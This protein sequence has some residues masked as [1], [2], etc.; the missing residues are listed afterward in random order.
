MHLVFHPFG[1]LVSRFVV[2]TI[3]F[4][5]T[6][7]K[8]HAIFIAVVII[9][10]RQMD[11]HV[12]LSILGAPGH[13]CRRGGQLSTP[14]VLADCQLGPRRITSEGGRTRCLLGRAAR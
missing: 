8:P 13:P 7:A 1:L 12:A 4:R 5:F 10:L 9:A 6:P 3:A 11:T 14:L 2:A